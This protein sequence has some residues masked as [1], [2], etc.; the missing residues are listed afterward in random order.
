MKK[1][2]YD[3]ITEQRKEAKKL[4]EPK[5]FYNKE[6]DILNI[7]W[8]P[9]L[10]YDCSVEAGSDFIFDISK[11]QTIKGIEIHGFMEKL[12]VDEELAKDKKVK[13]MIQMLREFQLCNNYQNEI[14]SLKDANVILNIVHEEA[15]KIIWKHKH[16]CQN[17]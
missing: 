15:K 12:K 6:D 1:Q 2:N 4:F 14:E 16:E 13:F 10:D 5:M 9:K 17:L 7:F 3:W 8:F 11:K